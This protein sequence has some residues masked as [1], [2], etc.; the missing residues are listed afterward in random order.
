MFDSFLGII[1]HRREAALALHS[2]HHLPAD[3]RPLLTG[4]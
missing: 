2:A 4:Y 3:L 1:L